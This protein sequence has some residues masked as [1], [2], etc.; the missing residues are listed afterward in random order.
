MDSTRAGEGHAKASAGTLVLGPSLNHR[1]AGHHR[2][3]G[4]S[5]WQLSKDPP[6]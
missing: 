1:P 3:L 6:F 4:L 5:M 2:T